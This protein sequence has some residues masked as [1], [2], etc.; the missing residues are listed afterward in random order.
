MASGE[1]VKNPD[2]FDSDRNDCCIANTKSILGDK[3]TVEYIGD[4]SIMLLIMLGLA[5]V[6]VW[7]T[8]YEGAIHRCCPCN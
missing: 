8:M 7:Q 3:L 2:T 4:G 6:E 5:G 1:P